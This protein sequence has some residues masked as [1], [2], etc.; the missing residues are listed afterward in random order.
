MKNSEKGQAGSYGPLSFF[1]CNVKA[2]FCFI[3]KLKVY[4]SDGMLTTKLC[5][6]FGTGFFYMALIL[7]TVVKLE[8]FLT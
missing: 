3:K 2:K 5:I 1:Y 4:F 8:Y 6:S 7:L